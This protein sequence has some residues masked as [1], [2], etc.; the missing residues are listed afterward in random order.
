MPPPPHWRQSCCVRR[1]CMRCST[2][3]AACRGWSGE[4]L[5]GSGRKCSGLRLSGGRRMRHTAHTPPP[6]STSAAHTTPPTLS[7]LHPRR[8]YLERHRPLTKY[9]AATHRHQQLPERVG[10]YTAQG[11]G[12]PAPAVGRALA[13]LPRRVAPAWRQLPLLH[14]LRCTHSHVPMMASGV[15]FLFPP[16]LPPAVLLD[17]LQAIPTATIVRLQPRDAYKQG[18]HMLLLQVGAVRGGGLYLHPL[19]SSAVDAAAPLP[20]VSASHPPGCPGMLRLGRS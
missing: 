2:C 1:R 19:P 18:A 12:A 7:H 6:P 4:Q 5:G 13:C 10:R 8:S 16:R 11:G 15:S 9:S 20:L 3:R 14:L 17:M